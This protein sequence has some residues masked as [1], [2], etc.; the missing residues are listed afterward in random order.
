M[1]RVRYRFCV[2]G[3]ALSQGQRQ[4]SRQAQHCRKVQYRFRGKRSSFA[5]DKEK[6]KD[7]KTKKHGE[8]GRKRERERER[9]RGRERESERAR[10]RERESERARERESERER[11]RESE[12]GRKGEEKARK[13]DKRRKSMATSRN[14]CKIRRRKFHLW[15]PATE[16]IL[17]GLTSE[18]ATSLRP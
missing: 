3:A 9:E 6:E 11:E 2:A 14:L 5:R 4:I 12:K 7:L 1:R 17:G 10:G 16:A 18:M 13:R 15:N 8:K